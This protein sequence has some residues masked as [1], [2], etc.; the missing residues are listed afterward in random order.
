M[1]TRVTRALLL[2]A[3]LLTV[4]ATAHGRA[5]TDVLVLENGDRITCEIK[6][7]YRGRLKASTSSMS[8][9]YIEWLDVV[10][11]KS[12][13]YFEIEDEDGYKYYGTPELTQEGQVRV[14]RA[15]A[16]VSL[17]KLQV[18]RITP[19]ET[20]FWSRIN[21]SVSLGISYTKSS[22]IGRTDF[23]FDVRYRVEKNFVQ[24]RGTSSVTS[25]AEQETITRSD[26]SL[27]Y[28]HLFARRVYS[29]L[30]GATFRNDDMGIA[31]R[32]TLSAGVGAH[33]VQ[34]NSSVLEAT[35]GVSVNREW[36][37]DAMTLPTNNLEG[38]LA[39]GYNIYIYNTPKTDLSTNVSVYPRLPDFDRLRV[40]ID[41]SWSQEVISD[42]TIVLTF[43]DN[44][45]SEPP[46]ENDAKNDWGFTTSIGYKF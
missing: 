41:A 34:T 16:V 36:A 30:T 39:T 25:E 17:E 9:V 43:W 12:Q 35:L 7:L 32:L 5:K 29:D 37:T 8:T 28:Q 42:F 21:G 19:I 14:T 44:Y 33:V 27:T 45:N 23:A 3:V 4:A 13:Y 26:A 11:L 22:Q 1:H 46:S 38:V 40:D 24:L 31:L 10:E 2:V 15:D 6:E 20:S 18:I